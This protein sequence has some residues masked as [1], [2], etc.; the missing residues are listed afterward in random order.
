MQN[1]SHILKKEIKFRSDVHK[2]TIMVPYV[3][4]NR[5]YIKSIGIFDC[6]LSATQ[7]F[8]L[9]IIHA[10]KM[11]SHVTVQNLPET[12]PNVSVVVTL[13]DC[14]CK[15]GDIHV[16]E[17]TPLHR[18]RLFVMKLLDEEGTNIEIGRLT[19]NT[20]FV[21][22]E[23][24]SIEDELNVTLPL[25]PEK[26]II[27]RRFTITRDIIECIFCFILFAFGIVSLFW[28]I[29]WIRPFLPVPERVKH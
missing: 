6:K 19:Y 11:P 28:I 20:K 7:S 9:N 22:P 5:C 21:K 15:H 13:D 29:H 1:A 10:W 12:L 8:E 26:I 2:G 24:N 17:Y 25:L 27:Y 3:K 14:E 16:G 23:Y 18:N 4:S